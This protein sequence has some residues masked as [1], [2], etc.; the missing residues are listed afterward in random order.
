VRS[1]VWRVA[2]RQRHRALGAFLR[3]RVI[4]IVPLYWRIALDF[5][6]RI[7]PGHF[8]TDLALDFL[9]STP[10]PGKVPAVRSA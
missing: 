7:D 9:Y 8:S 2:R 1:D 4:R 10:Q 3:K 5:A 6:A